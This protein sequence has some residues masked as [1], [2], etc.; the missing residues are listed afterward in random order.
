MPNVECLR[1]YTSRL[2][3]GGALLE[4]M[5]ALSLVWEDGQD[6][7]HQLALNVGGLPSRHRANEVIRRTFVPRLVES[8]PPNLCRVAA[9]L[10]RAGADRSIIVP[11]HYYLTADSEPLLWDFVVE[12][13]FLFA[14]TGHEVNTD[15]MVRFIDSKP[16]ERFAGRRP[17]LRCVGG[18]STRNLL[19][20]P[21]P[22]AHSPRSGTGRPWSQG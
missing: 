21:N 8:D 13:L 16:D 22:A 15:Q 3:K 12:E 17:R 1:P 11:L 20:C 7:N 18:P 14:G 10:E 2:Q 9:V 4:S 6:D 5:R 19:I